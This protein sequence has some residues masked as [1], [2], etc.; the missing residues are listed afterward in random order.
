MRSVRGE[1]H[2][3]SDFLSLLEA[4]Q[5]EVESGGCGHDGDQTAGD[6]EDERVDQAHEHAL[7]NSEQRLR[8]CLVAGMLRE[9]CPRCATQ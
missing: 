6:G 9:P 4:F 2:H 3:D 7:R 1:V 8:R 5:D